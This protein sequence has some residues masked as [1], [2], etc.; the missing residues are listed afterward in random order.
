MNALDLILLVVVM[1]GAAIS[2]R[3]GLIRTLISI[4]GMYVTVII[5]GYFYD[6]IGWTMADAFGLGLT[7]MHNLAFLL[8][9]VVVTA[10]VE[11]VSY[12]VFEE[13]SIPS[14]RKLD[15]LL[16]SLAGIFFG[17]L[18][19][20]I[21]LVPIQYG[22]VRTGGTLTDFVLGSTL[23]PNLNSMFDTAVLKIARPL[24]VDGIPKIYQAI[25]YLDV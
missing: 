7:T 25:Y 11:V 16:G 10:I 4:F 12:A 6:N 15:N 2:Y 20:A 9:L 14:L 8:I 13:T 23:V 17:A 18:W 19:A 24:F 1:V 5:A 21:L 3:R 22:I